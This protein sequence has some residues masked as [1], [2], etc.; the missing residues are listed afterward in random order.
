MPF[1]V[2]MLLVAYCLQRK[3]ISQALCFLFGFSM[4]LRPRELTSLKV[5]QLVK[6]PLTHRHTFGKWG[7]VL[8]PTEGEV[9]S[10]AG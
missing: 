3:L 1:S 10:K 7:V 5:G 2:L 8:H 6:P 4:Y 9:R